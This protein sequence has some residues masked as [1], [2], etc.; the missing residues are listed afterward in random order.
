MLNNVGICFMIK[1]ENSMSMPIELAGATYI[2]FCQKF[3]P[4]SI[5]ILKKL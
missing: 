2:A 3:V 5:K 4:K 1:G